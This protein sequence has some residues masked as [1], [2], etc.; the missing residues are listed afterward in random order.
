MSFDPRAYLSYLDDFDASDEE[1]IAVIETLWV[2]AQGLADRAHDLTPGQQLWT[3]SD[4]KNGHPNNVMVELGCVR[5]ARESAANDN[6]PSPAK[7][8]TA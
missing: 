1:K 2:V 8:G 3:V 4:R 6:A 5:I 7:K